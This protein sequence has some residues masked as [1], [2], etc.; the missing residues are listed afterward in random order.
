V[1]ALLDHA[2]VRRR[3]GALR[4]RERLA[5]GELTPVARPTHF[6]WGILLT[7]AAVVGTLGA[8][9]GVD[10]DGSTQATREPVVVNVKPAP[11]PPP[12]QPPP[13]TSQP[14]P[15]PPPA[16]STF[17][18]TAARGD[19]WFQ[20]RAG[21]FAGRV[22]YEGKL[23]LGETVRL[24]SRRLWIRFGGASDL[25]LFI[26]GKRARLPAFGTYDAFAGRRGVVADRT[27]H[28]ATAAQSP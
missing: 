19:S 25:D 28:Y 10:W 13:F 4:P 12:P 21:S 24:H 9:Y 3:S 26:N 7:G 23:R 1:R 6:E 22:L 20:V 16:R 15:K 18:F 27:D 14:P 5:Q 17:R 8:F 11:P 2:A